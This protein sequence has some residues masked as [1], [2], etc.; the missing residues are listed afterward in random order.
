MLLFIYSQGTVMLFAMGA[1]IFAIFFNNGPLNA[2]VVESVSPRIRSSAIAVNIF[3]IHVLGDEPSPPLIG[4][5]SDRTGSMQYAFL[6]AVFAIAAAAAILFY[7]MRF[8]PEKQMKQ[9]PARSAPVVS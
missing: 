1:A 2:A 9:T 6:P 4:W 5:I 3:L 7:G 8:A